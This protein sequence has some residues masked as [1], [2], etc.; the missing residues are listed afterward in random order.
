MST[1]Q[2][3]WQSSVLVKKSGGGKLPVVLLFSEGAKRSRGLYS[4]PLTCAYV[5]LVFWPI[6][7][8]YLLKEPKKWLS[9]LLLASLT[10]VLILTSSRTVQAV[11]AMTTGLQVFVS[12]RG[13]AR[14]LCVGLVL[15][16]IVGISFTKNPISDRFKSTVTQKSAL[17]SQGYPDDRVA[18]GT[19]L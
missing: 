17:R 19:Y 4:H 8:G 14:L 18:S 10:I 6:A 2:L 5:A 12:L 3:L 13:K 11:C 1:A 16:I 9:W 15:S 7:V